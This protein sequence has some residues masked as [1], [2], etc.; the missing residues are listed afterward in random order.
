MGA[1]PMR[2]TVVSPLEPQGRDGPAAHGQDA[3]TTVR[4]SPYRISPPAVRSRTIRWA[5]A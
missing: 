1:P 5:S 4:D 2:P 3:R